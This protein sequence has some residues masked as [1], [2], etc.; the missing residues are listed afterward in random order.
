MAVPRPGVGLPA[1]PRL[2]APVIVV[3]AAILVVGAIVI[4]LYTDLLWFR[5]V[6]YSSVFT[7]VLRTKALLFLVFGLLMALLIGSNIS[8][9]YRL[10]PP[11]RP[12]SLEQQNLERYRVA[13]EPFLRTVLVVSSVVFGIFAGLS[14]ASR[15]QVWL[16]FRNATSFGQRD[17]Q[18]NKD[19]SFFAMSYPFYR[20]VLGFLLTAVILSLLAAAATHYLFGGVRLQTA[21]EKV[22]PAARAHLSVLIG[23]VVLLKAVAYYLDRFGLLFSQ[24]GR[25][26]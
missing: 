6:G 5:E 10:R 17:A 26:Q 23:I 13:V 22:S 15:W 7:T 2:L 1:R 11:F 16:L 14:A 20:F 19:I 18:F 3:V 21:G 12:M 25:V 8:V 4:A 9:A 24:R